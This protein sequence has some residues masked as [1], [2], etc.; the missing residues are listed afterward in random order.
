[1]WFVL[2][3]ESAAAVAATIRRIEEASG[4]PVCAFPKLQEFFVDMRLPVRV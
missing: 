4:L 3:G 2:A 1:L